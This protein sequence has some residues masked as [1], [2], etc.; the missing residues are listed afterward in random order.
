MKQEDERIRREI[1]SAMDRS[2]VVHAGS[3]EV[4]V[5]DGAVTLSGKV[6]SVDARRATYEAAVLTKGVNKILDELEYESFVMPAEV[7]EG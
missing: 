4:G 5:K 3:V 6:S 7:H 2:Q 1:L